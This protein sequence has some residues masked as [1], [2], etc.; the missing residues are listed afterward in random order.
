[1]EV[2]FMWLGL[3]SS[4]PPSLPSLF[5]NCY[6]SKAAVCRE[7][8]SM[9]EIGGRKEERKEKAGQ[10]HFSSPFFKEKGRSGSDMISV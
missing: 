10:K 2:G 9:E 7:G 4:L 3:S 5:R 8:S 1:M 6:C